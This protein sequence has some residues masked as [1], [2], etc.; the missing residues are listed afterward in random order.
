MILSGL[1][2][3]HRV[4]AMCPQMT[5]NPGPM[6]SSSAKKFPKNKARESN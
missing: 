4:N 2:V 5:I 6:P 3:G 1:I